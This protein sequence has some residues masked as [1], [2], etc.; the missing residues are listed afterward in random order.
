MREKKQRYLQNSKISLQKYISE[1]SYFR[2]IN[3][4]RHKKKQE[5]NKFR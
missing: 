1:I 3:S 4:H 2:F 5:P